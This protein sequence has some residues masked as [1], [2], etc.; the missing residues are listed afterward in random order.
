[1]DMHEAPFCKKMTQLRIRVHTGGREI[2]ARLW[3]YI[4]LSVKLTLTPNITFCWVVC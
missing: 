3:E 2:T 4:G 1:M